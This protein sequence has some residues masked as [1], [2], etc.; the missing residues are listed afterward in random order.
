M[1]I[2]GWLAEL[3]Y[4]Q[5]AEIFAANDIDAEALPLITA[6]DLKEMGVASIGHRRLILQAASKLNQAPTGLAEASNAVSPTDTANGGVEH[7][8]E[9]RNLSVMFCDLVDFTKLSNAVDPEDLREHMAQL[10]QVIVEAIGP[11]SGFVA[12][13]LG[14]GVLV[15]F[16]YP[17]SHEYDAENA[18]SAALDIIA[19][20]EKMAPFGAQRPEVRIGIATGLTVVGRFGLSDDEIGESAVGRTVNLAARLQG[21]AEPNGVVVSVATRRLIGDLFNCAHLGEFELKGFDRP[22]EVWGVKGRSAA[23]DRFEA[24]RA[25]QRISPFRGRKA[26]TDLLIKRYNKA[27]AGDGLVVSILAEGGVGKSRLARRIVEHAGDAADPMAVLQCAPN[28][29]G[30]AFHPFRSYLA[31]LMGLT[32]SDPPEAAKRKVET[33]IAPTCGGSASNIALIA[34]FMRL[35]SFDKTPLAALSAQE[36]RRRLMELLR[37]LTLA[38]ARKTTVLILDDVQWADPSSQE[39]VNSLLPQLRKMPLLVIATCRPMPDGQWLRGADVETLELGRLDAEASFELLRAIAGDT[40]LPPETSEAILTRSNGVPVYIE[41]LMRGYLEAAPADRDTVEGVARVPETLAESLLSRLDRLEHG[42]RLALVAAVLGNQFPVSVLISMSEMDPDAAARGVSELLD[43][44]ILE[45]VPG[46][47]GD[48][49]AFRHL[50]LRDAAYEL[51]LRKDRVRLHRDIARHLLEAQPDMAEALPHIVAL[52]LENG[53]ELERAAA[54]WDYAGEQAAKR[55]AYEEAASYFRRALS[56]TRRLPASE[57]R[58]EREL[59]FRFNLVSC[60]VAGRGY[61]DPTAEEEMEKAVQLSRAAGRGDA[62]VPALTAKWVT[63]GAQDHTIRRQLAVQIF[64]AA[65]EGNDVDQLFANRVMATT[66]MFGGEFAQSLAC[67]DRFFDIYNEAVHEKALSVVGPS[68]HA[69]TMKFGLAEIYTLRNQLDLAD[70]WG[71]EVFAHADRLGETHNICHSIAFI[72]CLLAALR[73]RNDALQDY[74]TRLSDLSRTHDLPFWRGHA[75]LFRGVSLARG[76]EVERGFALARE[77]IDGLVASNAF[78]I[79]WFLVY[80][81]ACEKFGHLTEAVD[82]L[83]MVRPFQ[84][85]GERWMEAEFHRIAALVQIRRGGV[86]NGAVQSMTRSIETARRQG[87]TLLLN[88]ARADFERAAGAE[89]SFAENA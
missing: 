64:E 17:R 30:S 52:Q 43:A 14:D 34:E 36:R 24:L 35:S 31:R 71:T 83:E 33:T 4:P 57:A 19:S 41:E 49:L 67:I 45:E 2:K 48:T 51:L 85:R 32:A 7:L 15:Y 66:H 21:L 40:A 28:S 55:S 8:I 81:D 22:A 23:P 87:A 9:R 20:V 80:A 89:F 12:Q 69:L 54:Q 79:C 47:F 27:V 16:G 59:T 50:L 37:E 13:Y 42:R 78:S 39:L 38:L 61:A 44:R 76:G 1:D 6:D 74:S 86:S 18:V 63:V 65:R 29:V 60:L 11:Y 26:E 88:R 3:G 70:H 77:G 56:V 73:D 25:A 84:E 75:D 72:G 68:N 82:T 53:E 10:R 5:Y 62:L 46:Q 58:D